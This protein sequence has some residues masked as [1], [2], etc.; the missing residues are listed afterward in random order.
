MIG[1]V[2]LVSAPVECETDALPQAPV[3]DRGQG[4]EDGTPAH[5]REP[6]NVSR[7]KCRQGT[8]LRLPFT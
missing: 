5:A 3:A 4:R 1:V 8:H 2:V 6:A 7:G